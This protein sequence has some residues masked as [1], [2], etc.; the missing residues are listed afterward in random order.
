MSEKPTLKAWLILVLLSIIWGSSFILIKKGLLHLH[1]Q[2]VASI[3]IL[4]ASILLLPWATTR[5]RR[6][7]RRHTM[8]LLSVG[9]AGSFIPA[10]LFAIA[11][12]RIDSSTAG[13]LNALTPLWVIIIGSFLFHQR[14]SV[15]VATGL[16]IGFVGT[17]ILVMAGEGTSF[18][19]NP[20]GLL[21]L[22]ATVCYGFNLN[23]IKYK[24]ADLDAIT[25]TSVAIVAV[26]PVALIHLIFLT[27][28]SASFTLDP[29]W[30][31]SF[32]YVVLLGMM[33]TAI[34]LIMFNRLVQITSPVFTSSV[35][36]LIPIVAIMWGVWDDERI[37][38]LQY[39]GMGLILLG[40]FVANRSR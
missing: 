5:W 14:V 37:S 19:F 12:T 24:L 38:L 1:P 8:K 26:G 20:Y 36:Y 22:G 34:A 6:V 4:S 39:A 30:L 27:D 32:A 25:I 17:A 2:Q 15:R 40:V 31:L 10:F 29:P 16:F 7:Q 28:F 3:R 33:S 35:T 11:Q 23:L 21:V 13:V 18:S 9:L